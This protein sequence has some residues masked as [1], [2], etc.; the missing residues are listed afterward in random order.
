MGYGTPFTRIPFSAPT[1][2]SGQESS[3]DVSTNGLAIQA[4]FNTPGN[5]PANTT[6]FQL[7]DS[8]GAT[9]RVVEDANVS[10]IVIKDGVQVYPA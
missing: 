5:V 10:V 4:V 3:L 8:G 9:V 2:P 1:F 7:N 6:Q